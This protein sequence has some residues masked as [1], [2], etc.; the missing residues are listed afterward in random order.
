MVKTTTYP[1]TMPVAFARKG[2]TARK[3]L[4]LRCSWTSGMP[5]GLTTLN[6]K[7]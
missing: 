7:S 1:G 3:S 4:F 6:F 5:P 2:E